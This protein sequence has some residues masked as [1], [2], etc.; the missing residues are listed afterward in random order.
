[1][2]GAF[3]L[4]NALNYAM[5]LAAN[6]ILGDSGF[7]LFYTAVLIVNVAMAPSMALLLVMGRVLA[8][9]GATLGRPAVA[10]VTLRL[11]AFC[12]RWGLPA[13][14]ASAMLLIAGGMLLGIRTWPILV[15]IPATVLSLVI[16]EILRVSFQSLLL[17]RWSSALFVA[18]VAAQFTFVVLGLVMCRRVWPGILGI[19]VGTVLVALAFAPWFVRQARRA[20][21]ATAGIAVPY[22]Q[23]VPLVISYSLFVLVN[24]MDILLAY[25]V[26]PR[27][28]LDVYAASALLPKA[29]V[30]ATFPV[31]QIVLPVIVERRADGLSIRYPLLK[32]IT[33][34]TAMGV[35]AAGALW[36]LIPF[37][38]QSP[39][40]VR[41]LDMHV[42]T[43]L[44]IGAVGVSAAR[45]LVVG[46]IALGRAPLVI[47]QGVSVAAFA[48]AGATGPALIG[49]FAQAYAAVGWGLF[50]VALAVC[51]ATLLQSPA[52][53]GP[54]A[55][56]SS[57]S[58]A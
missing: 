4:G 54:A 9:A 1:V 16:V 57:T 49:R 26:L 51:C 6:R 43:T 52:G 18:S 22:R 20:A 44:A 28:A 7:G 50:L 40:A 31:A 21:I 34:A 10:R 47:V 29:I 36:V 14:A 24:N 56:R 46:E 55:I 45:V 3:L 19:L 30:T 37:V 41:G 25:W 2:T 5:M 17:F 15:L 12:L 48:I 39:F 53:H 23:E 35:V 58:Q 38:Q 32:A 27:A 8:D 11:L 13:A 42:M 33:M